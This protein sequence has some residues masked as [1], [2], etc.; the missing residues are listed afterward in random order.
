MKIFH[1]HIRKT[2]GTSF[3]DFL[4]D[5]LK[6]AKTCPIRSDFE[7]FT[8]VND[9]DKSAYFTD[10]DIISGH[11]YQ[12]AQFVPGEYKK[13]TLLRN[14]IHRVV[15]AY[16]QIANDKN[17]LQYAN[18]IGLSLSEAII[19]PQFAH[20]LWNGQTRALVAASGNNFESMTDLQRFECAMDYLDTFDIVGFQEDTATMATKLAT[21]LDIKP[22][23]LPRSNTQVTA[24]GVSKKEAFTCLPALTTRNRIDLA[25]YCEAISRFR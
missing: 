7:F 5:T 4:T 13:I 25:L 12:A 11:F 3:F 24:G 2:A 8:K 21:M 20:E 14:P 19:D 16:N 1:L 18:M 17:D 22:V 15:S 10:F 23:T 9:R 6:K